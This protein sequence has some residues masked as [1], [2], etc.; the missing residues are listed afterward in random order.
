MWN[1]STCDCKCNKTCE[2]DGYLDTENCACKEH[3]IDNLVL[4]CE[5]KILNLQERLQEKA[6]NCY[7]EGGKEKAK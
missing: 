1:P 7:H 2:I 6:Q 3:A 4:T 5:S